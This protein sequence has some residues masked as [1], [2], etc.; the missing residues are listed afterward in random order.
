MQATKIDSE[1]VTCNAHQRAVDT[2]LG[3]EEMNAD[4]HT[5]EYHTERCER[6]GEK[7]A[8]ERDAMKP[9]E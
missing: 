7:R 9:R 5:S 2:K 4:I 6:Q 1:R 8:I 3:D